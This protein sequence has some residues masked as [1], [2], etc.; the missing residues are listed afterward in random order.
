[1]AET[2]T[3]LYEA[4]SRESF[5]ILSEYA[6]KS[7][8]L[9]TINPD[10]QT[11]LASTDRFGTNDDPIRFLGGIIDT[12]ELSVQV[13]QEV[14]VKADILKQIADLT[15]ENE[16]LAKGKEKAEEDKKFYQDLYY[17]ESGN[18]DRIKK[19][20]AAIA[21]LIDAIGQ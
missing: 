13:S 7:G 2:V 21:T 16:T 17:K 9:V 12:K 10:K 15:N 1:M 20:V 11:I 4:N 18:T 19:Q 6:I 5:T 3:Y 8:A 14:D